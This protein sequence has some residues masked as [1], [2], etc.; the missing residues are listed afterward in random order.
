[1]MPFDIMSRD[2]V[3]GTLA[4]MQAAS[5]LLRVKHRHKQQQADKEAAAALRTMG[6][7]TVL[8]RP[9]PTRKPEW[10]APSLDE[11]SKGIPGNFKVRVSYRKNGKPYRTY[12]SPNGILYRSLAAVIRNLAPS[13]DETDV[14]ERSEDESMC[15]DDEDVTD[16]TI[17]LHIFVNDDVN[18]T[19]R[20]YLPMTTVGQVIEDVLPGATLFYKGVGKHNEERL[21]CVFGH[22]VRGDV[23]EVRLRDKPTIHTFVF[24]FNKH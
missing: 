14:E 20:E 1:M 23:Y 13:E 11:L 16:Y 18:T 9:R 15:E 12:R 21:Q 17:T 19:D 10:C 2:S 7:A 24:N 3:A 4:D 5:D 8:A 22:L 6:A